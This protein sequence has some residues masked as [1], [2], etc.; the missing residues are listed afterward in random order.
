M[1][2]GEW[3]YNS[4]FPNMNANGYAF[5]GRLHAN[6]I[7]KTQMGGGAKEKEQIRWYRHAANRKRAQ[8]TISKKGNC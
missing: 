4:L 1:W 3:F 8:Q 2:I 5:V 6:A 7:D